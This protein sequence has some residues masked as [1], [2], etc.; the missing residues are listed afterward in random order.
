MTSPSEWERREQRLSRLQKDPYRPP[1]WMGNQHLQTMWGPFVRGY[2]TTG[3][4][5]I[6]HWQ[7]PDNDTLQLYWEEGDEDKPLVLLLHGL[8]G[9]ATSTY[10]GGLN[11]AFKA[12]GWNVLALEFRSCSGRLNRAK[13]LYH[14][15]ETTDLDFVVREIGRRFP[16]RR[17]YIAGVSLGGNVLGKWMGEQGDE[18]PG[19]VAGGGS[20]SSPFDLTISGPHI[21]RVLFGVYVR[22]FLKTLIPKALGKAKQYPGWLEAE[23][24]RRSTTFEEFDTWATAAAHGFEDAWD[25]WQK[26]GCGQ[27]LSNVRCPLL[28]V[29]SAD[30][31]FNPGSTLPRKVAAESSWLYPLFT[32]KGGHVGFVSGSTPFHVRYWAEDKVVD[33]F[34]MLEDDVEGSR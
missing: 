18:I 28:L 4:R 31:P 33:F 15:G 9:S 1:W 11:E 19:H 17:L 5:R 25:Y 27:Y 7:T 29:A 34:Q 14:T 8:E 10:I 13:R 20:I 26:C 22:R 21:D 3:Q 24:I 2:Y 23:K 16:G 32:E 30:D 12:L 6:W